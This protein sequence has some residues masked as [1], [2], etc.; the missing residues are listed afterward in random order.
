M[1]LH[2]KTTLFSFKNSVVFSCS[3]VWRSHT[4]PIPA[5]VGSGLSD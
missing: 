2:E 1:A 3:V 4:I 5:V